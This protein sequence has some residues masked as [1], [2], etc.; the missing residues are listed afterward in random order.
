MTQAQGQP[1]KE[2]PVVKA[3]VSRLLL[4]AFSGFAIGVGMLSYLATLISPALI[5]LYPN[6]KYWPIAVVALGGLSNCCAHLAALFH[7][8]IVDFSKPLPDSQTSTAQEK[9]D[10]A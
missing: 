6:L 3:S 7:I 9:P 5:V 8:K 1:G 4:L 2:V 10:G